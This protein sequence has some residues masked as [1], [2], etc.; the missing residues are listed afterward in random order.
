[1]K[2]TDFSQP[3]FKK[4][5]FK[6]KKKVEQKWG[7]LTL[8]NSRFIFFFVTFILIIWFTLG[9]VFQDTIPHKKGKNISPVRVRV[10]KS[11]AIEK[12]TYYTLQGTLNALNKV[13][14][15]AE[16]AGTVIGIINPK[17]EHL[18]RNETILKL[19]IDSRFSKLKEAQALVSQRELEYKNAKKLSSKKFRSKTDVASA[20]SK[21][22]GA[23]AVLEQIQVEI[24]DTEIQAPFDGQVDKRYVELGDYVKIG[25]PLV[26]YVDLDVLLG[27]VHVAEKDIRLIKI[28]ALC[29]IDCNG[30]NRTGKVTFISSIADPQTRTYQ[31]EFT[32]NNKDH[33]IPDGIT[34]AVKIPIETS[35]AHLFS[36][37]AIAMNDQGIPGIKTVDDDNKV[38]FHKI[39]IL[40]HDA[41][42]IWVRDLPNKIRIITV[43]QFFVRTG[44]TVTPIDIKLKNKNQDKNVTDTSSH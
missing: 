23:Q 9:T 24:K 18:S 10:L 31:V 17:G 25:D 8:K 39:N 11:E 37:A 20:K 43:G 14:L 42:G 29:Q 38:L 26:D 12:T 7:P 5:L 27:V 30:V 35:M 41:T 34:A 21:L 22:E 40:N 4:N 19:S 36:P 44:D 13:T 28:N 32:I 15:R 6:I 1:M 16:T 33:K 3:S 2:Q